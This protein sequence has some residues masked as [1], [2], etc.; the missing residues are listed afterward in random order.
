MTSFVY[1]LSHFRLLPKRLICKL[2][3]EDK[4]LGLVIILYLTK[5]CKFTMV[6][7][8]HLWSEGYGISTK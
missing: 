3:I 2:H 7:K 1:V 6:N 5:F 8:G 4:I